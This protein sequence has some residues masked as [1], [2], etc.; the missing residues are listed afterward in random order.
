MYSNLWKTCWNAG[1]WGVLEGVT[2]G[3]EALL[4][5]LSPDIAGQQDRCDN[6]RE[7][8]PCTPSVAARR[9][10]MNRLSPVRPLLSLALS[11]GLAFPLAA[12]TTS[13]VSL[14][15]SADTAKVL[16]AKAPANAAELKLVQ[17][18]LLKVIDRVMP[19]TV[20]VEIRGAAGSGVIVNKEGLVLTAAH[21]VGRAGR[22]GWVELPD[23]RRLR[24]R[25]LG[26]DHDSDAGMFQIT[27]DLENLPFV[28]VS[29]G[30]DLKA[31]QWVVT[32][33]QPGGIVEDRAPP[34]RF[35]RVL[36]RGD[37]LLCTDCELVGGD[38]GGPLF[39]MK[40]EVVGI[41]SSIGP[42]VTHNFH[43]P[44]TSFNEG[45]DRLANGEVWGGHYENGA[46]P[47]PRLGVQGSAD[48]G[49]C[50]ITAIFPGMPAER[51]GLKEGDV[52]T[53][54]DGRPIN[55]FDELQ[56]I[57]FHKESGDR[58]KLS[59]SREGKSLEITAVL[60]GDER[61]TEESDED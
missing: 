46:E 36:F 50:V 19:A 24:G 52:I 53:A 48:A 41:H 40:G 54:V 5:L 18:Q 22:K 42:M 43:V 45:W 44:I 25:S 15:P 59:V 3:A 27:D 14:E 17:D 58:L 47:K 56:R 23:G 10:F 20:A 38:S 55:T 30:G 37:G 29:Q 9:T 2:V 34:V 51:A 7:P 60:G 1:F 33:G 35:G 21:V 32:I 6:Y 4:N 16:Q 12:Q 31:G 39:D 8:R 49:N 28:P 13:P 26:A 61:G 11:C 57:V